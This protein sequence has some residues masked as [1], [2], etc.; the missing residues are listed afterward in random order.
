MKN[1][2]ASFFNNIVTR[3]IAINIS[4]GILDIFLTSFLISY[5]MRSFEN[6]MVG[7]AVFYIFWAIMITL[8]FYLAGDRTKRG[9]KMTVFRVSILLRICA[10]II[11]GTCSLNLPIVILVASVLGL[12]DG[13][14]NLPWNNIISEKLSK[15]QLIKYTGYRQSVAHTMRVVLPMLVAMLITASSYSV[16]VWMVVPFSMLS[17]LLSFSIKS[18]PASNNGLKMK[19]YL[20]KCR[21]N[22]FNK[23]L[24]FCEFVRGM[25]VDRLLIVMPMLIVYFM[26][27]DFALG[28]VQSLASVVIIVSSAF[29]GRFLTLRGFPMLLTISSA[30]MLGSVLLF[31]SLHT[32]PSLV[33]YMLVYSVAGRIFFQLLEMNMTNGSNYSA[34]NRDN[35]VEYF[36]SRECCLNMGRAFSCMVLLVIGLLGGGANALGIMSLA[37]VILTVLLAFLA[38]SV[39]RDIY[40]A[41]QNIH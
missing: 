24:F 5:I 18:V 7:V 10:C 34:L 16:M 27:T 31:L 22:A 40:N 38:V 41:T 8:G 6:Q 37:M 23:K 1:K 36:I 26:H 3:L 21:K 4:Y 19:S 25:S 11:L 30:F 14:M 39:S 33:I 15:N 35:K 20:A 28:W 13:A 12:S 32:V 9:N 2:I 29:V 17:F